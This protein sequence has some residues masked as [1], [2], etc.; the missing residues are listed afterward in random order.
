MCCLAR[1]SAAH[2]HTLKLLIK[3]RERRWVALLLLSFGYL[4]T[5]NV[6]QLF[7][8]VRWVGLQVV[9]VPKFKPLKLCHVKYDE[10]AHL[11]SLNLLLFYMSSDCL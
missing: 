1:A 2:I 5:I 9:I 4:A 10:S 8:T 11:L 6:L 7:L 3:F